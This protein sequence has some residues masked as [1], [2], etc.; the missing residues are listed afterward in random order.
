MNYQKS[1][2]TYQKQIQLFKDES[3]WVIQMKNIFEV[4]CAKNAQTTQLFPK[5]KELV[6]A[7][8]WLCSKQPLSKEIK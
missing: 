4:V 2:K 3:V 7:F 1:P 5:Y 6:Q 8:E